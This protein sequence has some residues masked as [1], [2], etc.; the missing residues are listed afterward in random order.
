[1]S[2][3]HDQLS[4]ANKTHYN[5]MCSYL[6]SILTALRPFMLLA[7]LQLISGIIFLTAGTVDISTV[8][9]PRILIAD[10]IIAALFA[11]PPFIQHRRTL[12]K[13]AQN[14]L[15]DSASADFAI[16]EAHLKNRFRLGSRFM[17]IKGS[18]RAIDLHD[19]RGCEF[20]HRRIGGSF[21]WW[22]LLYMLDG[23]TLWVFECR[24]EFHDE[25]GHILRP[26]IKRATSAR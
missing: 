7:G 6:F 1:M 18:G 16:S 8:A 23:R 15:L 26:A 3:A 5:E 4:P 25:L 11:L 17:F 24:K 9:I 20:Q 22:L 12:Y 2:K 10:L 13:L 21:R 19:A 14:G